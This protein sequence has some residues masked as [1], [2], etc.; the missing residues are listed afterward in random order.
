MIHIIP[1]FF[2]QR[3]GLLAIHTFDPCTVSDFFCEVQFRALVCRGACPA[4]QSARPDFGLVFNGNC[5]ASY[6]LSVLAW[7]FLL[8]R[9]DRP[10]PRKTRGSRTTSGEPYH[11]WFCVFWPVLYP[12]QQRHTKNRKMTMAYFYIPSKT[13]STQNYPDCN[14]AFLQAPPD[15]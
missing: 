3:V 12:A 14:R 2:L 4:C 10:A 5:I 8:V 11:L 7:P 15:L 1:L 6:F 13:L 9:G